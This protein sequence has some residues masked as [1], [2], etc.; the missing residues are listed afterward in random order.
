MFP[1]GSASRAG[2]VGAEC[3][4]NEAYVPSFLFTC[5]EIGG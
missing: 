3:S 2:N 1:A 5:G 4:E